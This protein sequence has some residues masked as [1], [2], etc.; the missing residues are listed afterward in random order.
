M[1]TENITHLSGEQVETEQKSINKEIGKAALRTRQEVAD[2]IERAPE[3]YLTARA[4]AEKIGINKKTVGNKIKELQVEGIEYKDKRGIICTFLS[5]EQQQQI[6]DS[7]DY[8]ISA[9]EAPE[10]YLT[11]R[12]FAS[13]IG[14]DKATVGSKIKEL[15]IEGV[16]YKDKRG[17]ICT[18]LSPGEQNDLRDY[19]EESFAGTSIPENAVAFYLDLAKNSIIQSLRPDWLKNPDTGRNL[20]VDVFVNPPG[21]GIEYDGCFYHQDVERDVKKDNIAR[22]NGYHIIHIRED[23]C[24]EMPEGSYCIKRKNNND[25]TDLGECIRKC[26]EMLDIPIPDI[27]VIRDKKDIMAFMRQRVLVKLDSART[28]GELSVAF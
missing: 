21:I 14:V 4:L 11:A 9:D 24:P 20:E 3:G 16:E 6:K 2:S 12:A 27:D 17:I 18:F 28:F 26:F 22:Q 8:L 19:I 23:G 15:G 1:N 7:L 25:D 13:E 10:G 5:P